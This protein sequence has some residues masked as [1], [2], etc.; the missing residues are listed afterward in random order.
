MSSNGRIDDIR[1]KFP[2]VRWIYYPTLNI[3][4]TTIPEQRNL[5]VKESKGNIVVFIDAD[6]VPVKNWLNELY[7]LYR[8]DHET[9]IKLER[10]EHPH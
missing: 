5:G 9:H 3:K 7:K 2:E 1:D 10:K 6:C 4:K 8:K